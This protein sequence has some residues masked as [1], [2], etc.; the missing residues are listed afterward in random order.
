MIDDLRIIE[1]YLKDQ[2]RADLALVI[3]AVIYYLESNT[4]SD[5]DIDLSDEEGSANKEKIE[6][7][8]KDGFLSLK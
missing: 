6:V 4:S 8:E 1:D 3:E 2:N 5:E 7:I